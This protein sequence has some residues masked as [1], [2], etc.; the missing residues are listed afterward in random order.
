MPEWEEEDGVC[1][2]DRMSIHKLGLITVS[3]EYGSWIVCTVG[4]IEHNI[5]NWETERGRYKNQWMS[6]VRV[7]KGGTGYNSLLWLLQ[8]QKQIGL[9]VTA[10]D[11][12]NYASENRGMGVSTVDELEDR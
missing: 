6:L 8:Q 12:N 10:T 2:N 11:K 7:S 3:E 4:P 9:L 5:D 1:T